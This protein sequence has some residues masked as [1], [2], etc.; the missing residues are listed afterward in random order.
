ME[1][2]GWCQLNM[3]VHLYLCVTEER[4][5]EW[6]EDMDQRILCA[7]HEAWER[8]AVTG[9]TPIVVV[10]GWRSGAGFTNTMRI[11]MTPDKEKKLDEMH[12]LGSAN[13]LEDFDDHLD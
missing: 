13:D 9:G 10:T 1:G 6:V 7:I 3:G 12:L 11:I 2:L 8:K 5:K 4:D